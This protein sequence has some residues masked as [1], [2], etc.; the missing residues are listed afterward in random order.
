LLQNTY[1]IMQTF[2]EAIPE[3]KHCNTIMTIANQKTTCPTLHNLKFSLSSMQEM[4]FACNFIL[5]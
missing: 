1:R 3:K 5:E 2:F 4:K